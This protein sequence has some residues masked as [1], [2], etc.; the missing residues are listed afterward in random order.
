M[1]LYFKRWGG[2]L[3]SVALKQWGK[4]NFM[5]YDILFDDGLDMLIAKV[6]HAIEKGWM[7]MGGMVVAGN[8]SIGAGNLFLQAVTHEGNA[9]QPQ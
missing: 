2:N 8:Q 5:Q 9:G 6:N 7:P 4:G 1:L 3:R